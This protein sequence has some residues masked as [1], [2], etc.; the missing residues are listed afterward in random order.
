MSAT[1]LCAM[2]ILAGA[3]A[4]GQSYNFD[5]SAN[6]SLKGP[7]F[8]REVSLQNLSAQGTIGE[9]VGVVGI[10]TF[11]GAGNYSFSGQLTDSASKTGPAS[12]SSSGAYAVAANGFL[13]IACFA[14][15][16][17]VAFGGV[18]SVGPNAFTASAT[19]S[20]SPVFDLIIGI[21]MGSG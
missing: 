19:E 17:A 6:S 20:S 12:V 4:A 5:S 7:Y 15:K 11:D 3:I 14:G 10:A 8:V 13:R 1:R 21:P 18:G 16:G 2:P 9:A